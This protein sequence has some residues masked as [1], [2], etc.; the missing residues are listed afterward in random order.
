[1]SAIGA[2]WASASWTTPSWASGTWGIATPVT[3]TVTVITYVTQGTASPG[4]SEVSICNLA[5]SHLG[6]SKSIIA[7]TERSTEA[8]ACAMWYTRC[9]DELLRLFPWPF[10]VMQ[11]TLALVEADP[12]T[13]W[14]YSYAYPSEA[15]KLIREPGGV[16]TPTLEQIVPYVIGR[17]V[18]GGQLLYTDQ[19]FAT[20]E[21][22]KRMTDPEEFPQDFVIAL[23]YLIAS[24]ICAM[25]TSENRKE[26]TIAMLELYKMTLGAAMMT[27]ITDESPTLQPE[28]GFIAARN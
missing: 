1:M 26:N 15:L 18:T 10:A 11:A 20:I 23:S 2:A 28:S 27:A 6:V 5:L 8:R 13:E 17:S 25:V 3:P 21:Y 4:E 7:L 12:T 16:R 19:P 9:R 24:R 14:G 22:V